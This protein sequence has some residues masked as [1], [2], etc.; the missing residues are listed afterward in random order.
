VINQLSSR[1]S[2]TNSLKIV[3]LIA[4]LFLL[5]FALS[6]L[7]RQNRL[8]GELF[9]LQQYTEYGIKA[10]TLVHELQ[11]E[12]GLSSADSRVLNS[13]F[14]KQLAEQR[15]LTDKK[16]IEF[17]AYLAALDGSDKATKM[18]TIQRNY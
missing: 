2:K 10:G 18:V 13:G 5:Y 11:K 12:R 4:T 8:S 3:L 14:K 15:L 9:K 17:I 6:D 7:V 16:I 1:K